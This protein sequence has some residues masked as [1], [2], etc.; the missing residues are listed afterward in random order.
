MTTLPAWRTS[1]ASPIEYRLRGPNAEHQSH[2]L[3][4]YMTHLRRKLEKDSA[5]PR[6]LLTEPRVGYRLLTE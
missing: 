3:R 6:Y 2:Y 4:V 1:V 5:Q